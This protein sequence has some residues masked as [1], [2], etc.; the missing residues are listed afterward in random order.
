MLKTLLQAQFR[1]GDGR[2]GILESADCPQGY[3]SILSKD[4]YERN[5]QTDIIVIRYKVYDISLLLGN[6]HS[7]SCLS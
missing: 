7:I 6:F 3:F 4:S 5:R 1:D 2:R